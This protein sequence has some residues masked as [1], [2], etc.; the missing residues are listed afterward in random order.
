[1][2][3]K[4]KPT[5]PSLADSGYWVAD[6]SRDYSFAAYRCLHGDAFELG[7]GFADYLSVYALIR[8]LQKAQCIL[9]LLLD[10]ADYVFALVSYF[11]RV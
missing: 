5:N 9:R 1:M 4:T 11:K 8:L 6:W 7:Y 3:D 2:G 10:D